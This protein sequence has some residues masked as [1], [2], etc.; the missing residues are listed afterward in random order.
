MVA[1]FECTNGRNCD[2][3]WKI[4]KIEIV[5]D[6]FLRYGIKWIFIITYGII[7]RHCL[8]HDYGSINMYAVPLAM[9][10]HDVQLHSGIK[11]IFIGWDQ[12]I[13]RKSEQ[14]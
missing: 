10:F 1:N 8:T 3:D 4:N 6:V 5:H 9:V 13:S 14:N 2:G 11:W 7:R 12:A